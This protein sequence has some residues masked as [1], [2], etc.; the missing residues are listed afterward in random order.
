MTMPIWERRKLLRAATGLAVAGAAAVP[1]PTAAASTRGRGPSILQPNAGPRRGHYLAA[2]PDTV[3]WGRLPNRDSTPAAVIDSGSVITIDTVSHEGV[4]E[5]QGQDPMEYFTGHGVRPSQVLTDAVEVAAGVPHDGPGPHVITG[6]VAIRG[7]EPGHTLKIE[8]LDLR[9]RVPYG[10]VSNR[11]GKGALPGEY[12][13]AWV[14]RPELAAYFNPGGNISVFT[15]VGSR[16]GELVG[17]LPGELA[18][19]PLAPFLG[20]MGVARDT[21][22]LVNSVPPT[23]AGG[24]I[25]INDLGLGSTL[26]LPVRVPGALFFTGD[27]HMAQ[28]DG[29]VALTAMEGSLR[30]TFR[31]TTIPPGGPAPK[32]A[33]DEPFG[34]TRDHWVPIG[35]SDPDGPADGQQTSLDVAM[36]RAVRSALR[37][38]TE[39]RGMPEPLAYAYLS[40]ATDFQVSQVVDITT[41]IH[42]LIRK[43]DFGR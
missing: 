36:K 30:A 7:A 29:E 26:Y 16:R 13:D 35:L 4:L 10:V 20:V 12:P 40:A 24:N 9:L 22:E 17:V 2:R 3:T 38:L 33:F 27:P 21:S 32:L 8:V 25:D 37:F 5:D 31:L 41:G 6:P 14:G 18:R 39:E 43:T 28:G 15:K 1:T 42:G 34:E 11:H 23:D 19:F